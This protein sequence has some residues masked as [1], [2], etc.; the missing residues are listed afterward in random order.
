MKK[1][2]T[3]QEMAHIEQGLNPEP[4]MEAAGRAVARFGKGDT[5]LLVGKGNNG[6]DALAAGTFLLEQGC[7]VRAICPYTAEESSPLNQK[8]RTRFLQKGGRI[9]ES[10]EG[11][12]LLID[13]FLGTGFH[14]S[15]EPR[16][17]T[18]IDR[19]NASHIP[20]CAVDVPSAFLIRATDTVALGFAKRECFTPAGWEMTGRLHV[21]DIG[22]PEEKARPVAYLP[23]P[24]SLPPISRTRHKYQAGFVVG[25]CGSKKFP[26]AARLA[27]RAALR[28]GAGIVQ[29]FTPE[30]IGPVADELICQR[31]SRPL[32]KEALKRANALL[33]G[34][35]LGKN[36]CPSLKDVRQPCVIDADA[37]QS[38][39]QWPRQAI[40]TPHRGEML[41][42]VASEEELRPFTEKHQLVVVLKG[43]PTF[44]YSHGKLPIIIPH[45]DPGMATAGSGDVL[46]G[47]LAALLAQGLPCEE[48]A[49]LGTTLHALA[50]EAAAKDLTSYCMV[51]SDIIAHFPL[52]YKHFLHQ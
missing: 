18:W 10:F 39:T 22:L 20:I 50:G 17:K 44:I 31:W 25:F 5:V 35:G 27:G 19:A 49:V 37:L 6:G 7:I 46:T 1:V 33:I 4:L 14:G 30:E 13:G 34:P 41:R 24:L 2:V 43:A 38:T 36:K 47:L 21:V 3:A 15:I 29:L 42:L 40:L 52:V 48:A 11:A 16:L 28:G 23:G 51:A 32:W 26:G 12:Q 45:G 9:V 8:W